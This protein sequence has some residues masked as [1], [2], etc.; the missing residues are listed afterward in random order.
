MP[1]ND[2]HLASFAANSTEQEKVLTAY[3][4]KASSSMSGLGLPC[5]GAM[6]RPGNKQAS[7]LSQ[8]QITADAGNTQPYVSHLVLSQVS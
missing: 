5:T 7:S 4:H 3:R 6:T 8:P 1:Q 2:R